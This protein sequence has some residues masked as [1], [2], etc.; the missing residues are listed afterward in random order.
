MALFSFS[1]GGAKA[2][3]FGGNAFGS[4]VDPRVTEQ[5]RVRSFIKAKK[6]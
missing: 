1:G 6:K 5:L 4:S 2:N 3:Q